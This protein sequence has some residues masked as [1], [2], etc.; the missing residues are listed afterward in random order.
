MT[1][2]T[3]LK[4]ADAF[5]AALDRMSGEFAM[6][7]PAHIP[8]ERFKRVVMTAVNMSPGLLNA[9][10]HS[11]F[12]AAMKAAQDGL[13]PDGREGAFVLFKNSVQ[14]MPMIGGIIKKMRQSGELSSITARAVYEK[15]RF[16]YVLGD[17]ER[18]VHEPNFDEDRGAF[19]LVYAI[20]RLSDGT[21]Q[22][23]VMTKAEIDKVRG[24]SRAA[25]NGPWVS[26]FEEM[27]RKTVVRRLS[28]Y[29]PMSTEIDQ[30]LRR[31]DAFSVSRAA[32][33]GRPTGD[34]F[35]GQTIEIEAGEAEGGDEGKT[36]PGKLDRFEE[37]D[38]AQEDGR[39]AQS[40]P[41]VFAASRAALDRATSLD[42]LQSTLEGLNLSLL[43]EADEAA[44]REHASKRAGAM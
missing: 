39:P 26:W 30:V 38:A 9:D 5:R 36:K 19:R 6:A 33:E 35:D 25:N 21:V 37:G 41:G 43:S 29:L 2:S 44:L 16:E 7:L 23:E 40:S 10:R 1:A 14:W 27:A 18:I 20:A 28:K 17:E 32:Q 12:G 8:P 15:D 13:L 22:R 4:P 34:D 42:D 11:L 31:D 24:A 3:A